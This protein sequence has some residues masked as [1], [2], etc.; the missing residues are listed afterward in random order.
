MSSFAALGVGLLAANIAYWRA[1]DVVNGTGPRG[2]VAQILADRRGDEAIVVLDL[3]QYLPVKYYAGP[4]A[5]VRLVRPAIEPF[6]GPH[7]IRP[8]DLIEPDAVERELSRGVW[9]VGTLPVPS[10]VSAIEGLTPD[11][12]IFTTS[13]QE[14]HKRIYVNHYVARAAGP[15]P[16][17]TS[18]RGATP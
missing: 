18:D 17:G 16:A 5:E 8:G 6:W 15:G 1:L 9:V 2:A 13:Y 12:R 14:L 10:N 11:R 4:F 7:V 3:Y